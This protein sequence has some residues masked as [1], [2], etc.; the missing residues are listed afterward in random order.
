MNIV[1]LIGWEVSLY[2]V[3]GMKT[4]IFASVPKRV[5]NGAEKGFR[6]VYS[7]ASVIA[8]ETHLHGVEMS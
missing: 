3:T 7:Y 2:V 8:H 5:A 4:L 6:I 1:L